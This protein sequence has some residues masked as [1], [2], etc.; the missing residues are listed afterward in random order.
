MFFDF[1]K[2]IL[3]DQ[4]DHF[5]VEVVTKRF[6]P[7]A[8]KIVQIADDMVVLFNE[9]LAPVFGHSVSGLDIAKCEELLNE[10]LKK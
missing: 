3:N 10:T 7:V 1:G 2:Q 5:G 6:H 4:E 9:K 8:F